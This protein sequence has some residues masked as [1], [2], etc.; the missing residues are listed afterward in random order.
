MIEGC[1]YHIRIFFSKMHCE[2]TTLRIDA[3]WLLTNFESGRLVPKV[4]G[5]GSSQSRM[6]YPFDLNIN[7][8]LPK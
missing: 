2:I 3:K 6:K 7:Y 4:W 1:F 5:G 8:L